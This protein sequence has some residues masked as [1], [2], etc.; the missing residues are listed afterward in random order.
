MG[1]LLL[2]LALAL[3][4]AAPAPAQSVVQGLDHIPVVVKDLERA[5]ADFEALGFVLKPGRPHANGLR[6]AHAKFPDGTEIELIT[7]GQAV[8]SLS[9]RYVDWLK[10]GEGPVMLGLF[11][12]MQLGMSPEQNYLFFGL[13]QRSPTDRPEHFAH[14]NTAFS[15]QRAW[16]AG[17]PVEPPL[18]ALAERV[19]DGVPSC[20]PFGA[21][22]ATLHLPD[23]EIVLLPTSARNLLDRPVVAATVTVRSLD[24]VR[25][26]VANPIE[27][28]MR[29]SLWVRTHGLWLEFRV[30]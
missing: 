4:F 13:R 26:F 6:N 14:P 5:K 28:C 10:A 11:S 29:D 18:R 12:L 3:S 9:T 17:D 30:R 16:L 21:A 2:A 7:A 23:G 15:L 8:E 19:S 1:R 25:R 20:S 24:A 27:G 22:T